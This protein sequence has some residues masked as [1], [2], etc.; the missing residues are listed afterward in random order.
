MPSCVRA[1]RRRCNRS[2]NDRGIITSGRTR[3]AAPRGNASIGRGRSDCTSLMNYPRT[4]SVGSARRRFL[5]CFCWFLPTRHERDDAL[6]RAGRGGSILVLSGSLVISFRLFE[7]LHTSTPPAL[8]MYPSNSIDLG[9]R[10]ES[11]GS[12]GPA[13]R[14][15]LPEILKT[16][17]EF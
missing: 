17:T 5:L 14:S 2:S 10:Q 4:L 15:A 6:P 9:A 13:F 7:V 3:R 8:T 1:L 16:T 12:C 11:D